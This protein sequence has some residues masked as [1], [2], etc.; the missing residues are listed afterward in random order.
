MAMYTRQRGGKL[1]I[2]VQPMRG[3]G[4][5]RGHHVVDHVRHADFVV[6]HVRQADRELSSSLAV[7]GKAAAEELLLRASGQSSLFGRPSWCA[8]CAKKMITQPTSKQSD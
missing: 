1:L 7:P 2:V 4:V 5:S 6:E 8:P 3:A